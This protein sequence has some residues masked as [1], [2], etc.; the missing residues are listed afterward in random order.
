MPSAHGVRMSRPKTRKRCG[1]EKIENLQMH[2]FIL[3]KKSMATDY[4]Y[5]MKSTGN[6]PL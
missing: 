3:G 2:S 5:L 6:G 1:E 4:I